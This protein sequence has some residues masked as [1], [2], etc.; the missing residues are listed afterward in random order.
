MFKNYLKIAI[1]NL[2]KHKGFSFL[3]ISGLAI[4]L[5]AGFLILLYVGFELSYDRF[6]S[7]SDRIYRVISD[8]ETPTG[9]VQNSEPAWAVPPN[10]QL[11]FPE[12]ESAVRV[13]EMNILVN[14]G[15]QNY[16]E[17]NSLSADPDFFKMFDFEL[18]SGEEENTLIA[19][20]S[21]VLSETTAKKYFGNSNPIGKSLKIL[22][23]GFLAKVTGVMKDIPENSHIK[24]DI[25]LSMTTFTE[26]LDKELNNKWD[27]YDPDAY[28][29]LSPNTDPEALATKFPDFLERNDGESMKA[30]KVNVLLF[31][32]PFNDVYLKSDR[33]TKISGNIDNIYIF[34]LVAIFILLIACINFINLT[35][36]RSVE[37]AKEVGIRKVIG[38]GK[39][40]LGL[41]FIGESVIISFFAFLMTLVLTILLLPYFNELAG[42]IVSE[43]ILL[44]P[45]HIL[46]LLAISLSIGVVA[47]IYP[48]FILSSFR[49]VSVLKGSFSTGT[50]GVM[51]RKGLV[52]AQ[53]SISIA[54]IIGTIII[55][56]QM[57][58]MRNQEL[59]FDKEQTLVLSYPKKEIKDAIDNLPGVKSTSL[60]SSIPGG[61]NP[62]AYSKIENLN[63]DEQ[64]LDIDL[65]FVDFDAI[66][67]FDMKIIEG[68]GFS[69]DFPTDATEAMVIN[70]TAVKLLGYT[71]AADALGA[72]F[73]Q[74]GRNGR[75]IGVVK[76]FHFKSLKENIKPLT[77]R[78]EP[79]RT[80]LL[81]VKLA[82]RDITRT[83]AS[84]EERWKTIVPSVPFDYYFLD[85]FF[86]RQYRT[87]ARFGNL[88][89][90]FAA[91]A[92]LIS[93]LG[94]LG[95]AAYS[96]LQRNKEIGIRKV[97]GSTVMRVVGLLSIDFLKLV[98]IA[99]LIAS[100]IAWMAMNSWLMDFAYRI[101]IQWWM[102]ALAGAS[103]LL[104]A[105]L[106][107]SFHAIKASLMNPVK[108]LHTE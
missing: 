27:W 66:S 36:A 31:L 32:E 80:G 81:T 20:F 48:A 50:R 6:H 41:Q 17:A 2:W 25:I 76:D 29:L 3:N 74:W 52:I 37:R 88:F 43:S 1:R 97:L 42:K 59:G 100:P 57:E 12:V 60:V 54:M 21:I 46:I 55:Y 13:M 62:I 53:F 19:P 16:N 40:H 71:S 49:P 26:E 39:R 79:N 89:L 10:M 51:L 18:L 61:D 34:S 87:E 102:F 90:N 47:G 83:V 98:G 93:C 28:V 95:L 84:I 38:A 70:E 24:A 65:Y 105:L 106:T 101:D 103:A 30:L 7:K 15:E 63:G 44:T 23:D 22:D 108:S 91:L 86:D 73:E 78:I 69:R 14:N 68:R 75:V 58:Y 94:L 99:F 64:I 67:Q 5:T 104:I 8:I 35:T 92:I 9:L 85:E 45:Y 82:S 4:G 33:Y 56:N 77:L 11:E 72:K 96:T 107:V